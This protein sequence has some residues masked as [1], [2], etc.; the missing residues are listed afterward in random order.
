MGVRKSVFGSSMEKQCFRKLRETWG[1]NYNLYHN[2]PFLNVFTTKDND[3]VQVSEEEYDRLKKT[4]IDFTLCDKNDTPLV[5]LEFDGM[6]DGFNVGSTY[7]LK[8]GSQGNKARRVFT[9]LK[10]R[11]AHASL[12]P[13][14]VL[15]SEEF[16]GLSNAV[17]LTIADGLIGEVLSHRAASESIGK[18]FD[19]KEYGHTQEEFDSLS[20]FEQSEIIDDWVVGIKIESDYRNNPIR[21]KVAELEKK[22]GVSGHSW[23]FPNDRRNDCKNWVGVECTVNNNQGIGIGKICLPNY[24]SPYCWF[25][26]H[27]AMEIAN[28]LALEDLRK[29]KE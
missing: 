27:I 25:S 16:R 26:V 21:R 19:P 9:E 10:L 24:S 14:L 23:T 17:R 1:E 5:C 22:C 11:I 7:H 4:S 18:G 12:F 15:G 6:Q 3:L 2:L 28:L 29:D 8:D 20:E 13:Y